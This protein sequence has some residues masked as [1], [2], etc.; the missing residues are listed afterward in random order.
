M[1]RRGPAFLALL[2][3]LIAPA[4]SRAS[5]AWATYLKMYTCTDMIALRDTVWMAT[6]E[7]GLVRYIRS[8]DRFESITRE[9][10]GLA[11]NSLTALAHDRSGRLWVGTPGKGVSRL[12]TDLSTWDLVNAFD[13]LPS[14][15]VNVLEADGDT[16]WIGTQRG[17]ALWDGTQIAGAVPDLGTP[18]P[19][20]S[21]VVTGIVV[22]RDSLFVSTEDGAYVS[23]LSQHLATWASIDTGLAANR[24]IR[25]LVSDG[26]EVFAL[27]GGATYRWNMVT[28][29][30]GVAGG[31]GSVKHLR[32]HFHLIL[33]ST[34]TGL[35]VWNFN[36][37]DPVPGSPVADN[38]ATGGVEFATDPVLHAWAF[39]APQRKLF[40]ETP[41][42]WTARTP[43]GPPGNNVQ[44]V[45]ADGSHTWLNTYAEGGGRF[46]GT[47]WRNYPTVTSPATQDTTFINPVFAFTLLRDVA[48][49]KWIANW[50]QAIERI[51][52][53]TNPPTFRHVAVPPSQQ[54]S[55][56]RHTYGWAGAADDEGYVYIGGDT[57][58]RGARLPV[59]I[60]VYAPDGTLRIVWKATNAGL[61]DDQV[62]AIAIAKDVLGNLTAWA[63]F[64]G[65]GVATASLNNSIGRTA[66]PTFAPLASTANKDIFG[67]VAHG[68][69]VW[70]L[71]T[72]DLLRF[73]T[74]SRVLQSTSQIPA[75]PAPRGAVHPLDVAPDGT[76]WVAS[77][78]GV[79]MYKPGGGFEDFKAGN[80]PLAD[81]EVRAV[82]VER[83]SGV[84]W[85][86]TAA[87]LNRYD[88]Y[89]RP[90][91]PPRIASLRFTVY[92]NPATLTEVGLDLRLK[93]NAAGYEGEI[94]DLNGRVLRRF[95]ADANGRIVWDGRDHDGRL[96][97]PGVYFVHARGGGREG[98]ARVVVLR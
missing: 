24:N 91:A 43:P 83:S 84:V 47:V 54:D 6:G 44:N 32:D 68:D 59:G 38:S 69:S 19:F 48:G 82:S 89:Y 36:R 81:N 61:L 33:C 23:R 63:G 52:D 39:S 62:R 25:G 14:D 66:L 65:K 55:L 56:A 26:R 5:G 58:D 17:I 20:R 98:A 35:W 45:L 7:A 4:S 49:R 86:G 73:R 70:V 78:D 60:D 1:F 74:T 75:G 21:N 97:R 80:S 41:T 30:W 37:W 40:E 92:P 22:L 77:V 27:L 51:D 42:V 15:T 16:M 18:S 95:L 28:K 10:G 34:S 29:Q 46:D 93:G 72:S 57:N 71:T 94:I 13:G 64:P 31:Q 76:V 11:S 50:D 87:G 12:A 85:I 90:P 67:I 2:L 88:P 79:R 8:A 96:V 9:P 53:S 3:V